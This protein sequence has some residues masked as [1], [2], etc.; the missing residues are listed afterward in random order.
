VRFIDDDQRNRAA[1]N[2]V[3]QAAI[4]RLGGE[5]DELVRAAAKVFETSAPFFEG[6]RRVDRAR[7]KAELL[8]RVDLI[9]HQGDQRR[10]HQH[11]SRHHAR[12]Q[13][14]RE[15]FAGARRHHRDAITAGQDCVD[16]FFLAGA[17]FGVAEN[18]LENLVRG[19][20]RELHAQI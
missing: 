15:R 12:R 8:E 2:Q 9:F 13:H 16:D 14:E 19:F 1:A 20:L 17:E 4:Q 10:E 7:M 6:Q 18:F 3:A 5:V 11:G